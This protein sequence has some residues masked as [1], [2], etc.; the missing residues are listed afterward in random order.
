MKLVEKIIRIIILVGVAL[1][2]ILAVKDKDWTQGIFWLLTFI[3]LTY[4]PFISKSD[5][6]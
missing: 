5:K 2:M 3:T 6:K 1:C 4:L